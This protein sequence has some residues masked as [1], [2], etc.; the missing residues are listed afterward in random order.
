MKKRLLTLATAGVMA[1]SMSMTSFAGYWYADRYFD[2][3]YHNDNGESINNGWH[4]INGKCY[5]FHDYNVYRNTTT[6]DG[7]T[8][9]E[10][11]AWTV[12]GVVQIKAGENPDYCKNLMEFAPIGE[13]LVVIPIEVTDCG[14]YYDVNSEIKHDLSEP[15]E[16]I[17]KKC[18]VRVRKSATV[19]WNSWSDSQKKLVA[20][21]ITM[22]E[23]MKVQ[24]SIRMTDDI[25]QDSEGYVISFSDINGV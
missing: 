3:Y 7:Y 11:G 10:E 25:V 18:H 13:G 22:D 1:I 2:W 8:V 20:K 16:D 5:C 9:N 24:N 23:Y 15:L 12:N 21:D 19:H 14:D 6:P 17:M 4:W